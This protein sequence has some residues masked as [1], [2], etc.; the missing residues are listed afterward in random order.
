MSVGVKIGFLDFEGRFGDVGLGLHFIVLCCVRQ[1][2]QKCCSISLL[3][4]ANVVFL[5]GNVSA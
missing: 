1:H 5:A 2:Q 3:F 4:F